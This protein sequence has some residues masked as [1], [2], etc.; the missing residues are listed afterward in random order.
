MMTTIIAAVVFMGLIVAAMAVG[1]IFSNKP[2]K[3]SCGGLNA[4][5]MKEDCEICGGN[6]QVCE[7]Q[8]KKDQMQKTATQQSEK[9]AALSYDAQRS[10]GKNASA[11]AGERKI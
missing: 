11:K 1:V 3:G 7:E 5:G 9:A 2:I 10:D 4:I 8:Q 6:D